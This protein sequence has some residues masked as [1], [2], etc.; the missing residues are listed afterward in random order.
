VP[1]PTGATT[2]NVVVSVG[3]VA[4]NGVA[5]IVTAGS[6]SIKLVQHTSK[7]AGITNSST[8]AFPT[9]NTAGN[10]IAVI[11]RAGK[12]ARR[13]TFRIL[14]QTHIDRLSFST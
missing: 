9:N 2:G 8:L 10:F 6:G 14:T 11:I 3:G 1:V 4:S 12:S 13:S 5:F 7:D